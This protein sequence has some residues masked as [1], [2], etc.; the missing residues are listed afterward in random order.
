LHLYI[1]NKISIDLLKSNMN[2]NRL[3][4]NWDHLNK[5]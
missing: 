2:R 5:L 3:Y 1:E 4:F